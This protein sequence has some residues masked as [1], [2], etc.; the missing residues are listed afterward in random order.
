MNNYDE[1]KDPLIVSE[2]WQYVVFSDTHLYSDVWECVIVKESNRFMKIKGFV[3][4]F[5]TLTLYVDG[6]IHIKGDLNQ[7]ITE[8]PNWFTLWQHPH[9]KTVKQEVEAIIKMK[10]ISPLRARDQLKKYVNRGFKDD[11]GLY[12]CGVMVRDFSDKTVRE[13]CS[14]WY[15]EFESGV[16]RDQISI[17]YVFWKHGY[18]PD[19]F[20]DSIFN[21]Y[22]IWGKHL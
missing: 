13:I 17:P 8:V 21:K 19:T 20:D 3:E 9:R 18:K 1:L 14:D 5:Q 22:F 10:G 11:M 4:M 15:Y 7:F 6:S 16:K 2:G 12:Q